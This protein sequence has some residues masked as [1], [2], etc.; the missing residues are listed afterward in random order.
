MVYIVIIYYLINIYDICNYVLLH[1][2]DNVYILIWD[3]QFL[4]KYI[5]FL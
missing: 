5:D 2:K 4:Y 3:Y 1:N